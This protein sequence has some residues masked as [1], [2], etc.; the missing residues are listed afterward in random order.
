MF[1]DFF[2]YVDWDKWCDEVGNVVEYFLKMVWIVCEC[3]GE[4]WLEGDCFC[5]LVLV[6]WY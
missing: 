3:C 4:V 1:F 2:K 6:W 5:V